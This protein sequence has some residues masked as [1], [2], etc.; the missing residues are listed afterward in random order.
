[1]TLIKEFKLS[2]YKDYELFANTE[3]VEPSKGVNVSSLVIGTSD[4]VE[5]L[6]SLLSVVVVLKSVEPSKGV[7]VSSLV[8]VTSDSVEVLLSL[9]SVVIVLKSVEVLL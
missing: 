6:L 3:S 8:T 5:V 7:N 2:S 1:M 9:L 4:S